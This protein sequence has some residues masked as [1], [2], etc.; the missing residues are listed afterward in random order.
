MQ[1][2]IN[3]MCR[4]YRST[5]R[6]V[7]D[8]EAHNEC[9]PNQGVTQDRHSRHGEQTDDAVVAGCRASLAKTD[10]GKEVPSQDVQT[11]FAAI[12]LP[13][14]MYREERSRKPPIA[15]LH[16]HCRYNNG[17]FKGGEAREKWGLPEGNGFRAMLLA[18]S[19]HRR[20]P[21]TAS[22]PCAACAVHR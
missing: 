13:Q 14:Y 2:L 18:A 6:A 22:Q 12:R 8:V 15:P 9:L 3:E 20:G 17:S 4:V 16:G 7:K 19:I 11:S 1:T 10:K 5:P 21:S